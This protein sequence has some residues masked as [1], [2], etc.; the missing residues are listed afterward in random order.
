[1]IPGDPILANLNNEIQQ[2]KAKGRFLSRLKENTGMKKVRKVDILDKY[3][4]VFQLDRDR[5]TVYVLKGI[6]IWQKICSKEP[7]NS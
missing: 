1:V 6:I 7:G 3:E 2:D 5:N 4:L